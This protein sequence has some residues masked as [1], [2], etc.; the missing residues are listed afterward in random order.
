M[1]LRK[2]IKFHLEIVR[3]GVLVGEILSFSSSP[4][5]ILGGCLNDSGKK[6]ITILLC[7]TSLTVWAKPNLRL[8]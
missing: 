3:R 6:K 5:L 4:V 8:V 1:K 2:E 7:Q